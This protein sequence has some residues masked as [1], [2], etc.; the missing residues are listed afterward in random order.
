MTPWN[1]MRAE[2]TGAGTTAAFNVTNV[3]S[4]WGVCK[5]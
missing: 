5:N 2:V 4:M 3:R 1:G